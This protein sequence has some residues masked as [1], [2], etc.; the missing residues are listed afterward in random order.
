MTTKVSS[1]G[2]TITTRSSCKTTNLTIIPATPLASVLTPP[3]LSSCDRRLNADLRRQRLCSEGVGNGSRSDAGWALSALGAP[4]L[5]V[6]TDLDRSV[7]GRIGLRQ[8]T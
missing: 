3:G 2:S 4:S 7:A 1:S 8:A 6:L 5:A